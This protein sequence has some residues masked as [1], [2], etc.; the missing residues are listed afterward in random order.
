[1]KLLDYKYYTHYII[2][3]YTSIKNYI[4]INILSTYYVQYLYM[5]DIF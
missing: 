5:L 2:S 4:Y 1:M 3:Y